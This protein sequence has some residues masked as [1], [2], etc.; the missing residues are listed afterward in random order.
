MVYVPISM[1]LFV[2]GNASSGTSGNP[3]PFGTGICDRNWRFIVTDLN[4]V[5]VTVLDRLASERTVTPK[6]GEPLEVTGTV[7]SDNPEVNLPHTDGFPMLAE[8]VRQLYCLRRD[9]TTPPYYTARASTL[10]LQVD[11]AAHSEDARTRFTAWDPWQYWFSV[12]V[13]QSSF[14]RN[15]VAGKFGTD[16]RLLTPE[17][18]FY[19]Q[20]MGADDVILD[21]LRTTRA[22]MNLFAPNSSRDLFV[23]IFNGTLQ[24][25]SSPSINGPWSIQQGTSV[26]QAL[27]D[28]MTS[29][30]CDITL[31]PIYDPVGRSGILSELNI[32]DARV[33]DNGAGYYNY[34][35]V[36][37]W[38]RPGRSLVGVDNL[39]DGTG[40]ANHI[41]YFNGQGGPPVPALYDN[42]SIE[43]YGE[44]WSQDFYP[45][46]T[47]K[48]GVIATAALS[49][50]LR[51]NFKETLTVNPAPE[52]SPEPFVD[53][54]L[55]DRVPIYASNK[56]RQ[57]I[58][59]SPLPY[60]WQRIYGIPISI[61]DN[62]TETV[63]QLLVGP[64]GGPP[65]VEGN[66]NTAFRTSTVGGS[67]RPTQRVGAVRGGQ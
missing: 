19:P 62:G 46:T 55:G 60:A 36:F 17:G 48:Q 33:P 6:F 56:M 28:I 20:S 39:F 30:A 57:E 65:V 1:R 34:G 40:R 9:S 14:A 7:P 66:I 51:K 5:T 4:G 23:D 64:V 10:I 45:A 37:A 8:G 18:M 63:S 67:L 35:A 26:G 54:N 38:D 21:I 50:S 42:D 25:C 11:D 53:Y 59:P 2:Q 31:T 12:P 43:L 24:S 47:Q 61:D 52:R 29:G 13:L 44:Y 22:A 32:W 27:R 49:L 16:G 15:G 41:Q 58:P 3:T